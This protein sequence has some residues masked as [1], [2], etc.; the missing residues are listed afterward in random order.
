[1]NMAE[2]ILAAHR[3][4]KRVAPASLSIRGWIWC[5]PTILPRPSPS[6]SSSVLALKKSSTPL[7]SLWWRTIL[8]RIKISPR[9]NRRKRCVSSAAEQG[10]KFFDVGRNGHRARAV[11]GAGSVLPGDLVIGADSHTCTYGAVGAF[12]TG[13]GSTDIAAAM[14]TGDIWMKVPP[15]IKFVY[16]GKLG[17]WV[18]G[19]DLILY[20]IGQIGVDGALYSAME[21]TAKPSRT[22]HGRPLYDGEHGD[23]GRRQSGH[24]PCR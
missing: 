5:C 18:G 3:G 17:N 9:P 2:K 6:T 22:V 7:K 13:M 16:N 21:F 10:V 23:R 19:K 20:L 8:S 24:L 1:M 14:A 11:A 12:S 4:R 15:T